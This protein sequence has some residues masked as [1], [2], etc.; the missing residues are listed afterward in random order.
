MRWDGMA[1]E[2]AAL[3][4]GSHV[5]PS[6]CGRLAALRPA[7]VVSVNG[8]AVLNLQQMYTLVQQLHATADFMTFE[9]YC[10]GGNAVVTTSTAVAATTL[11]ETLKLYRVPAAASPEL[12][13]ANDD[14]GSTLGSA[15]SGDDGS[16]ASV[17]RDGRGGAPF[18]A[19]TG[20]SISV[21]SGPRSRRRA[22]AAWPGIGLA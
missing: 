4:S 5:H 11:E 19:R 14:A 15:W 10:T 8:H 1:L 7:Q 13:E 6:S 20:P 21:A 12:A 16:A 18:G 17:A 3:Y 9:V 22:R 2:G